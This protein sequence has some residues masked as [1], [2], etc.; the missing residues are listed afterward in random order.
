MRFFLICALLLTL[1][2]G[3]MPALAKQKGQIP[4]R[5]LILP[6]F[7]IGAMTGDAAG[8]AQLLYETYLAGGD[9]YEIRGGYDGHKLYVRDGIAMYVTG[10]GKVNAA[11]SMMAVLQD[12]RFDFS[13]A[14]VLALGCAGGAEGVAV[15]GDVCVVTSVVDY[16]MGYHT[17][18]QET[19]GGEE[20][21]WYP[22]PELSKAAVVRLN[23][24]LTDRVY[25][26]VKDVPVYGHEAVRAYMKESFSDAAW[27]TRAPKVLKGTAVTSDSYWKG[28]FNHRQAVRKAEA[29]GC[30]EPF[31][32]SEMEDVAIARTLE[33]MGMLDRLIILRDCVNMDV[34][35][36]GMT[37]EKMWG[38]GKAENP[39]MEMKYIDE[40]LFPMARQSSFNVACAIIEGL[41]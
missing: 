7:E 8:E 21:T 25:G 24:E 26:L 13:D 39:E 16:D 3:P 5:M 15:L 19:E 27:A 18:L 29:Y 17:D 38:S 32:V 40:I 9:E 41:L 2:K 4:I 37:P 1:I 11:V 20:A 12:E 28:G 6:K 35:P 10:M 36:K 22:D 34:F 31:T 30:A 33:R 14:Y 23:P